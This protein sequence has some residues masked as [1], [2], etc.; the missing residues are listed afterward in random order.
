MAVARPFPATGAV[1]RRGLAAIV[2]ERSWRRGHVA[3][4]AAF[5]L[6]IALAVLAPWIAHDD[7]T[8]AT[9]T[10]FSAPS[11]RHPLGT[12]DL[13]RDLF[14]RVLFGLR[15]S[16]AS[17]V[18]VIA[19]GIVIGGLVGVLAGALGGVV[20]ALLMRIT[21]VFLALP[22]PLLAIAAVAA[23]GPGLSHTLIAVAAVWWP[24]YARVVRGEVRALITR[25]HVDAARLAGVS[26]SRLFF[27]HLLP[28]AMPPVLVTASLDVQNLVLTLAG[29][30]FLGL[31]APDP[32]P[33]LGAMVARGQDYLVGH[34]WI[35]LAP[36]AA[37][38]LLA[39]TSNLAGDA[40]RD[41][42]D[43]RR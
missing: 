9:G 24:W 29:L 15:T 3:A 12:D 11:L 32:A 8:S 43:H 40:L 7:P 28:G 37:V 14:S 19:S 16:L 36:A 38:F 33:E 10:A 39:V 13:G 27:R 1:A 22:G 34:P 18:A 4:L 30:S 20:D 2:G 26:R 31:G 17:A 5:A 23:L 6:V 42:R 35:P 41:L 25:P 21:D